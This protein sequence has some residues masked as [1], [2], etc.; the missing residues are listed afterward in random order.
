MKKYFL[1]LAIEPSV[2]L[3]HVGSLTSTSHSDDETS[4]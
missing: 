3:A 2:S 4:F 1:E